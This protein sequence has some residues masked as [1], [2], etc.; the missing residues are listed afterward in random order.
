MYNRAF[1]FNGIGSKPEKLL[2]QFTPELMDRYET[3][4]EE[5]FARLGLDMDMD[6]N[7]G[8]SEKAAEWMVPFLCDRVVYEYFI[9]KGI[10]PDIGAGYSSG[11][12]SA[13]ACFGSIRHEDAHD[14]VMSHLS[15]FRGLQEKGFKLDMGI[16]IGF[17][18]DEL[19][20][21]L[22]DKFTSDE[23]V[24]GS[25][26]SDFHVMISGKAEAVEKAI[27]L[28]LSEGAI[29]AF[30]MNTGTAFHHPL[31]EQFSTEYI[32]L[33]NRLDYKEPE[34]PLISV[35]DQT[36]LKTVDEVRKEN[37]LNV[38]TPMRWDLALKKLE[39]LGVKEFFDVSANGA[40]KKFSRVSRKCKIYT[41]E[42][43]IGGRY[44][45]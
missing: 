8:H 39:E 12:V 42:D 30:T 22:C 34:Y 37:L 16:I 20:E 13:S 11:I 5:A 18:Y 43:V 32:S 27:A 17:N 19:K 26:N 24:I 7:T 23:L 6:K 15:M 2:A 36:V 33:C 9:G 41:L 4:R 3:Y 29:K 1:L 28:C 40:I 25:G 35:F 10:I 21:L 14:I 45:L 44:T 38:F 31:M